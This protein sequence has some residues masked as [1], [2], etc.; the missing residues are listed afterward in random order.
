MTLRKII[1]ENYEIEL[2]EGADKSLALEYEKK[3]TRE[4]KDY[5]AF[6]SYRFVKG[7]G[8]RLSKIGDILSIGGK[9]K[10]FE[11]WKSNEVI[12]LKV[13]FAYVNKTS[14]EDLE[15]IRNGLKNAGLEK[16]L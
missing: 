8:R 12:S 13:L 4:L 11:E 1:R 3:I 10:I 16:S 6:D 5:V 2:P 7:R 15:I 14:E 9:I